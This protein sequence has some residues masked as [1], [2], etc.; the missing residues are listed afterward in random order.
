MTVWQEDARA[1]RV[2]RKSEWAHYALT[3]NFSPFYF[4]KSPVTGNLESCK[5]DRVPGPASLR[6]TQLFA[7][8]SFAV[9]VGAAAPCQGT[10]VRCSL[11]TGA[12]A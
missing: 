6:R 2:D 12:A 8:R 5:T 3:K 10:E 11:L 9:R 1:L 7:S 4:L